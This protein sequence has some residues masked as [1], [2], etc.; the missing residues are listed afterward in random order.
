MR[1]EHAWSCD[2]DREVHSGGALRIPVPEAR[3][4]PAYSLPRAPQRETV[5]VK[6]METE[7]YQKLRLPKRCAVATAV[8]GETKTTHNDFGKPSLASSRVLTAAR[9]GD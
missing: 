9:P 7:L 1:R 2:S 5:V 6:P 8:G 4:R 3:L